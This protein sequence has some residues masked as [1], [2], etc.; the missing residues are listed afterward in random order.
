M[1]YLSHAVLA[2]FVT[3]SAF[4]QS[5]PIVS[6]ITPDRGPAAGGT[7]VTIGGNNFLPAVQ[8]VVP[9]P[10][11]VTFG[12]VT[13][14]IK[15]ESDA[16]LVV[17]TPAHPGGT[18]DVTVH[19][20]GRNSTTVQ[21]AFTFDEGIEA[22]YEQ[23]LLPVYLDGT[24]PGANGTQWKTDLWIRNNAF[25]GATLA[26][27]PCP[28]G[29]VCPPVIPLTFTLNPGLSLHN[30]PP[31]FQTPDANTSRVLWVREPSNVSFSLRFADVSRSSLNGGT[32]MP[33]IR[34]NEL[35]RENSQLFNVPLSTQFRVL[36]R[37]YDLAYPVSKFRLTFHA[38]T[39]ADEPAQHSVEIT[40]ITP[41]TGEFRSEAAYAQFDVTD[42]LRMERTWPEAVRIE[43]TPLTPGSRYWAFASVTNNETQLVTLVTPQ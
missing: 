27:W 13:V 4:A 21:D 10:A 12:D 30:L 6:S 7:E 25:E 43:V 18:V 28:A 5:S 1:K 36:L 14:P 34:E 37:V 20:A 42:L 32:D 19:V 23:V 24:V 9:C 29:Q 17:V 40:A 38:Q 3:L 33:V 39:E 11:T 41:Q 26:P 2:V 16:R 35:L 15:S 8:C 22:G 31:F